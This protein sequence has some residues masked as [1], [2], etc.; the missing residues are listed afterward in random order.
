[1]AIWSLD[2]VSIVSTL[3]ADPKSGNR[4]NQFGS[5][6]ARRVMSTLLPTIS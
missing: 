2:T 5:I 3:P 1:M 4:G 6:F